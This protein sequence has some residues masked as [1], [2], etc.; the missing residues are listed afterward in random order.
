MRIPRFYF[1]DALA[2]GARV[3]LP[4][5]AAHHAVRVLRMGEGDA[6]SLFNGDNHAG[7]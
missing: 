2:L 1:P 5:E 6:V 4:K 7:F 3:A